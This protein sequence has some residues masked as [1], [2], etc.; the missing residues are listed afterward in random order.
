TNPLGFR[1]GITKDYHPDWSARPKI[2]SRHVWEDKQVRDCTDAYARGRDASSAGSRKKDGGAEG[3]G[4]VRIKR[5]TDSLLVEIHAGSPAALIRSYSRGIEQ[6]KMGVQKEL[7][8][9]SRVGRVR[10]ALVEIPEPYGEPNILA[11]YI[12]LQLRNRVAFRRTVKRAI[13]LAKRNGRRGIKIQIAGRLNGAEI[14]RVEW[15]REGRVPLQTLRAKID[16]CYYPAQTVY[17]V[18]GTKVWI[19]KD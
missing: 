10:I 19:L 15:A 4:R 18:L 12:A 9:D 6:L 7:S 1:L 16:Y 14:A 13:G 8:S 17:G 2:H 3:I 5:K 11:K